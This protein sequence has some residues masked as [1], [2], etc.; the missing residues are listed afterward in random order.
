M[1][2]LEPLVDPWM[3]REQRGE[4]FVRSDPSRRLYRPVKDSSYWRLRAEGIK[5]RSGS[6]SGPSADWGSALSLH[7]QVHLPGGAGQV[8]QLSP[9]CRWRGASFDSASLNLLEEG[10]R[11]GP[12]GEDEEEAGSHRGE[13]EQPNGV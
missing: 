4:A 6:W 12:H 7:S 11:Q 3:R 8:F 1:G 9:M 10:D 13:E 5:P 2:A